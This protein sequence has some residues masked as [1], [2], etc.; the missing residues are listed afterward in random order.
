MARH[1][2][3]PAAFCWLIMLASA[4]I[5]AETTIDVSETN[6]NQNWRE[7]VEKVSLCDIENLSIYYDFGS[8]QMSS[9]GN[10]NNEC[11]ITLDREIEQPNGG[12]EY[13]CSP[14]AIREIDWFYGVEE[15]QI[16]NGPPQVSDTCE[17][18][19]PTAKNIVGRSNT[20]LI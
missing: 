15:G 20:V 8:I 10:S 11:L 1:K 2:S 3:I 19:V 13:L 4:N 12:T 14:S 7:L 17:E 6:D 5:F 18:K 9:G 16:L